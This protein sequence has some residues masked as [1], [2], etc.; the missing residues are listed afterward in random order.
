MYNRRVASRLLSAFSIHQRA[1]SARR[2]IADRR[3]CSQLSNEQADVRTVREVNL[4]NHIHHRV[5]LPVTHGSDGKARIERATRTSYSCKAQTYSKPEAFLWLSCMSMH[6]A[7]P[8]PRNTRGRSRQDR[9]TN[10]QHCRRT[11]NVLHGAT[12]YK[13]PSTNLARSLRSI[14]YGDMHLIPSPMHASGIFILRFDADGTSC[15]TTVWLSDNAC[16]TR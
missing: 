3:P 10:T 1:T 8:N 9:R 4:A 16:A 2:G 12:V 6:G 11:P 15:V 7:A 5:L 14:S 13:R